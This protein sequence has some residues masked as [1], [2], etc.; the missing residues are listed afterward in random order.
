MIHYKVG[1]ARE[2]KVPPDFRVPLTPEQCSLV[3]VKFPNVEIIVQN[4]PIRTFSDDEYRAQGI[5]VQ[6]DLSECDIIMGVKEFVPETL[7]ENKTYIFFSHTLKKQPYNKTLLRTVLQKKIRLIDY[8]VMKNRI[9]KRLI[10][11]GRYAGIVGCYNGFRTLGL[12]SQSYHILKASECENRIQLE[13]E[14]KKVTLLD[15]CKIVLTG[16]GRVGYGAREIFDLLP[17]LEV[18]PEEFLTE[19]F[20]QPVFTHLSLE[21]Y[22]SR[23]DGA[24][25][26]KS[27]FYS[28]PENYKSVFEKYSNVA[29]M[30]VAGHYWSENSPIILTQEALKETR[31]SVLADISCDINGPLAPTIKAST[32]GNP[33]YGYNPITGLED[34]FLTA[35]NIAVMAVDNLPCELPK[36]ASE[37]FGY[38]LIRS[39]FPALFVEDPDDVIGRATETTFEGE[40]TPKFAYLS[41]YVDAVQ[42]N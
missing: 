28:N 4:S 11:F 20:D 30:F 8:E 19:K 26:E 36:D 5:R 35:G 31:L 34:E 41:D 16:G 17:I 22:Y 1:I 25:F 37:D 23:K 40:L 27:D 15:S 2:G 38:E 14:L 21:D 24:E 39:I 32:I 6:E 18:S 29:D 3:Q 10:G 33:I 13:E 42:N 7:L 12:K 9:G